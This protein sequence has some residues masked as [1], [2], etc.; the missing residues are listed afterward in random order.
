[1][2]IPR[3]SSCNLK[4]RKKRMPHVSRSLF[5]IPRGHCPKFQVSLQGGDTLW[6]AAI[7]SAADMRPRRAGAGKLA[8]VPDYAGRAL[9]VG[10]KVLA[11]WQG[12][13]VR[14]PGVVAA[15]HV[16]GTFDI[17]FDDGD[18]EP[19]MPV[20]R[21]GA[22]GPEIRHFDGTP[23][24][25]TGAKDPSQKPAR[26][27]KRT[28]KAPAQATSHKHTR[29]ANAP[30]QQT[31]PTDIHAGVSRANMHMGFAHMRVQP[32]VLGQD[33]RERLEHRMMFTYQNSTINA[34]GD[35]VLRT[36]HVSLHDIVNNVDPVMRRMH[37]AALFDFMVFLYTCPPTGYA[38]MHALLGEHDPLG[39]FVPRERERLQRLFER[40]AA[41][42]ASHTQRH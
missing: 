18:F 10:D 23:V 9:H 26:K 29:Q 17:R 33:Q 34:Q 12:G 38:R 15:E 24:L 28:A 35:A 40:H 13:G 16:D 11:R 31:P 32:G 39:A 8:A 22:D 5:L 30:P 3:V 1:M 25:R 27:R 37:T 19:H 4:K 36:E 41:A 6:L 42:E 2:S 7:M 14:F 20:Q 21:K